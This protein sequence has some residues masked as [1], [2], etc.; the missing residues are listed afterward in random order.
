MTQ[1]TVMIPGI[2]R[3]VPAGVNTTRILSAPPQK[4]GGNVAP[5]DGMTPQP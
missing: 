3:L 4:F 5:V 1:K 2:V